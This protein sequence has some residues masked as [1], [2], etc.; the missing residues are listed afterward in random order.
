MMIQDKQARDPAQRETYFM[1]LQWV[2]NALEA[3]L[4][5]CGE[6]VS[7]AQ[8]A[9]TLE[10]STDTVQR[11]LEDLQQTYAGP[12]RGLL[13]LQLEDRWQLATKNEFGEVVKKILD[14]RRNTPLSPAALEVL[15][16]VAYNQPVSRSFIDQVRGVDSGSAVQTLQA[17]GLIEEAG[18][19][20]LPGHPVSFATTDTFLR[21]F[22]LESLAQL[23]PLHQE[24]EAEDAEETEASEGP[25]KEGALS[26]EVPQD[27]AADAGASEVG[28]APDTPETA[29][30]APETNGTA[31]DTPETTGDGN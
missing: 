23:P 12:E 30:D 3:L 6:P 2:K 14:T 26:G 11:I 7:T 18:R 31:S 1:E 19:L 28:T 13:L 25:E 29:S 16:I 24:L 9:Q 5:A 27:A 15:A 17:R 21:C 8:L 4:F 22:D 20:D 10:V